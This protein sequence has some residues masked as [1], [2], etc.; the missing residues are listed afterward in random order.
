MERWPWAVAVRFTWPVAGGVTRFAVVRVGRRAT[1]G[2]VV[3]CGSVQEAG[4]GGLGGR[5]APLWTVGG[6]GRAARGESAGCGRRAAAAWGP[7]HRLL[8]S[9]VS[10]RRGPGCG[11]GALRAR[12]ARHQ[13]VGR[14]S[15]VLSTPGW[16]GRRWPGRG[17]W[18]PE[19]LAVG[20][21]VAGWPLPGPV[22]FAGPSAQRLAKRATPPATGHVNRTATAYDHPRRTHEPSRQ[23]S[24]PWLLCVPCSGE[25]G[26]SE[27][28]SD[29]VPLSR[30]P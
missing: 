9:L 19:W 22:V 7:Q 26:K 21:P 23:P 18:S 29:L 14:G 11:C 2:G 20:G 4:A 17:V 24:P 25:A 1:R 10:A 28:T 5:R 15:P 30:C 12:S 16:G 27:R 8:A 13:P 6:P 3:G